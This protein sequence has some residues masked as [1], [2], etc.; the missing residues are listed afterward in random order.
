M[1]R[2]CSSDRY[3]VLNMVADGAETHKLLRR[4][5]MLGCGEMLGFLFSK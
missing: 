4:L 3:A 1:H 2:T 5:R